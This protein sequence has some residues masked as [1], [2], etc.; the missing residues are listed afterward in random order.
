MLCCI[1][2]E[3]VATGWWASHWTT[4]AADLSIADRMAS[5]RSK[6][7]VVQ[8]SVASTFIET[9]I[10]E[11]KWAALVGPI[12]PNRQCSRRERPPWSSLVLQGEMREHAGCFVRLL[13][14]KK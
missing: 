4:L 12:A 8:A 13:Q 1:E 11:R 3:D 14:L 9:S 5:K 10:L 2:D 6:Y 7:R